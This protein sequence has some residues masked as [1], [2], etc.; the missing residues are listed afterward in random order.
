MTDVISAIIVGNSDVLRKTT[1]I[2][3]N[4]N[5]FHVHGISKRVDRSSRYKKLIE[6]INREPTNDLEIVYMYY[7]TV[8]PNFLEIFNDPEYSPTFKSLVTH[9]IID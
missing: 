6:C 8:G 3:F 9:I 2:R 7:D 4:P 1:W 5:Q